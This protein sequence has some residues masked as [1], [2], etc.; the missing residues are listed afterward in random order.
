MTT[1][2]SAP[3]NALPAWTSPMSGRFAE[4]FAS[5]RI[6]WPIRSA[7]KCGHFDKEGKED[8]HE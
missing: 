5:I 1:R 6:S 2:G 7:W 3:G 8:G 4:S